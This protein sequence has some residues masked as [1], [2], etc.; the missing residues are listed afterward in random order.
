MGGVEIKGIL[1]NPLV[2]NILLSKSVLNLLIISS[3]LLMLVPNSSY[4]ASEGNRYSYSAKGSSTT[5]SSISGMGE[6]SVG[7]DRD[8]ND[9]SKSIN[10]RSILEK[11]LRENPGEKVREYQK[12]S[13]ENE[14]DKN[15]G[16]FWYPQVSL[17]GYTDNQR[18]ARIYSRDNLSSSRSYPNGYVG[19][20]FGEYTIFNWGKDYLN[21]LNTKGELERKQETLF[22]ER[23]RLK[24][25]LIRFYFDLVRAKNIERIV[26]DYVRQSTFVYRVSREKA[27]LKKIN[28]Q[29]YY[30]SRTQYLLG[31]QEYNQSRIERRNIEKEFAYV[32]GDE[33]SSVYHPTEV[34][35]FRKLRIS[36]DEAIRLFAEHNSQVKDRK[37]ALIYANRIFERTL[38]DNLPL[39]KFS[40]NLGAYLHTFSADSAADRYSTVRI[41]DDHSLT[42]APGGKNVEMRAMISVSWN[43]FGEKGFFNTRDRM[44]AYYQKVITKTEYDNTMQWVE[45]TV[46][47]LYQQ[48]MELEEQVNITGPLAQNAKKEYNYTLDN[49]LSQKASFV[50]WKDSL[51]SLRRAEELLET[52]K[53]RHLALKLELAALIGIEDFPGENFEKLAIRS[54]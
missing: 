49:Y 53:F 9:K 50:D 13:L 8:K 42:N 36:V 2:S 6:D 38:K 20:S 28:E 10:L 3:N 4:A 12:L 39:P 54:E 25:D 14:Q 11:G 24:L 17:V 35:E 7:E 30:Q 16:K 19:V 18:I 32:L 33:S 43:I 51:L 1:S 31:Q 22:E 21:Y 37:E 23:L 27:A 26:K 46:R 52:V 5:K 45:N 15:F 29:H 41:E 48:I 44:S 40:I 47:K 34:L